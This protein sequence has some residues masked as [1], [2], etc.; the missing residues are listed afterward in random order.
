MK[1][2][3]TDKEESK[4]IKGMKKFF[5][6]PA[7]IIILLV[8]LNAFLLIYI[9]NYNEKNR[10]YIGEINKDDVQ[11]VNVH[12]F[13]NGDMNYFYASNATYLGEEKQ[14]YSYQIGYYAVDKDNKYIE[15]ATRSKELDK[16][17]PLSEI[18]TEMSGW[19]F[20]E[21]DKSEYFFTNEVLK[22]MDNLHF[23]IKASTKKGEKNAD[24]VIDYPVNATKVTK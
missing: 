10:I 13:T 6:N 24:V 3:K 8:L 7:P 14:I 17:A 5:N 20:A 9:S 18:V 19:N 21:S 23:V 15:L 1:K 22:H 11:V 12:Y 2:T 4:V 16:K